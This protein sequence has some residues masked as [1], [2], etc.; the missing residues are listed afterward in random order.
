YAASGTGGRYTFNMLGNPSTNTAPIPFILYA[1]GANRGFLLDQSSPSVITGT[2]NPQGKGAG[3]LSPSE[4][5]GTFAAATTRSGSSEVDPLAANL[6]LTFANTGACDSNCVS[7]T[8]YDSA[9][10]AGVALAG[11][12]QPNTF[13]SSGYGPIALTAPSAQNYVIYV[14]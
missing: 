6:L 9:S 14:I 10:P 5:A 13:L 11:T 7:G 1:S 8:L 12:V 4:L 3:I 2:M